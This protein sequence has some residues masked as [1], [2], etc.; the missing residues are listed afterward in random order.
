[1]EGCISNNVFFFFNDDVYGLKINLKFLF[2]IF[3]LKYRSVR[4]YEVGV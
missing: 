3:L 2:S 1:M 4:V